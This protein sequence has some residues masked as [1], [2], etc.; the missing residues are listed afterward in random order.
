MPVENPPQLGHEGHEVGRGH[1]PRQAGALGQVADPGPHGE[2]VGR[3]VVAEHAG[4]A[5]VGHQ[6]PEQ[7]LDQGRLAGP[8]GADQPGAARPDHHVDPVESLDGPV[9][10]AEAFDLRDQHEPVTSNGSGRDDPATFSH[11]PQRRSG[12]ERITAMAKPTPVY[13]ELGAKKVFA[14]SIDFPGWC[15]S[16]KTEEAALAVLAEYAPRYA[17]VAKLAKVAFPARPEFEVV[18]R[19]KGSTSTDFGIPYE[20]AEADAEPLTARQAARQ[21]GLVRA[22][23]ALLDRVAKTSPPELRKGPR[24]GGRDRDKMLDHVLGAEAAYARQLGIKRPQPDLT[25]R[26]AIRALREEIA[27]ALEGSSDGSPLTPKGWPPRYAAR[28]VA[29]HVLDHAWEMQD[30]REPSR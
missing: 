4:P 2:R 9:P 14:C 27:A 6:Q 5:L 26:K 15:R 12:Y 17:E 8:V 13:L 18:E 20:V 16:A 29:W 3:D 21:V 23:W 24:G 25:D 22:A 1:V 19:L 30:R 11:P 7:Q 28:R 10:L